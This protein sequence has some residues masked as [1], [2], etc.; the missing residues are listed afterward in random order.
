MKKLFFAVMMAIAFICVGVQNVNAQD[1]YPYRDYTFNVSVGGGVSLVDE[2]VSPTF[3]VRLGFES[4][5]VLVEGEFSYLSIDN[6]NNGR[7]NWDKDERETLSTM[8]AGVNIGAKLVQGNYGYLAAMLYTGYAIQ[9]DRFR[10]R[11]YCWDCDYYYGGYDY[12]C[13][14]GS[15]RDYHGKM[16]FGLGL[17]GSV[18]FSRFGIFA[19]ARFQ[20]IPVK[21]MGEDK[22]GLVANAGF[23]FYF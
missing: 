8:T 20:N 19:E 12:C 17:Q 1:Y 7:P 3:G 23:K 21:G 10:G 5:I 11:D 15:R 22:W 16:Y 9:E 2:A 6:N 18:D 13:D 14:Y 4:C